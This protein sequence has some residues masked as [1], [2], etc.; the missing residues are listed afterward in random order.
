[1]NNK[2]NSNEM[3]AKLKETASL[4]PTDSGVYLMKD[5]EGKIIYIG[6]AKSIRNRLKSYFTGEK[7][8]KTSVLL[9]NLYSIETIIVK[10]EYEALLLE[11]TLIKQHSPRYNISLKDGKTY[12]LIKITNEKFPRII[13]T[14][15]IVKDDGL[16]FG[17]FPN[18]QAVNTTLALIDKIFPLRK[19][20]KMKKNGCMYYHIGRCMAPC[21]KKII[22][23]DYSSHV[24]LVQKLLEGETEAIF[25]DLTEQMHNAARELKF[26][27]AAEIRN[28][29]K[30][31]EGLSVEDSLVDDKNIE[32]RDYIAWAM[33][34]VL[35]TFTVFSMRDGK[36]TGR[37]LYRARSA[38]SE[39]ESLEVFITSYYDTGRQPPPKVYVQKI[40]SQNS[41]ENQNNLLSDWFMEKFSYIP[42]LLNPFDKHHSAILAM[43]H[44]NAQEDLQKRLKE[45]GAGFALDEL[46]QVL[47]LQ[48]KPYRIE[49][50]D[51]SH[52]DGKYPVASLVSFKN[53]IPDKKNYRHFKLRT[54]IGLIDDYAAM[55]EVIQRR[56]TRILNENKELPDFILVDGGLGQVNAAKQVLDE[57]EITCDI[58]GL[59][60]QNEEI[61]LAQA[62]EP[63]VLSKRS[64]A[65]KILQFVRDESHRFALNLNK[66]L[67][68]KDIR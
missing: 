52:L 10:N 18:G 24:R 22:A 47:G 26:E 62:K 55:R 21:I 11:N 66:K 56:Y 12:P 13:K 43:A 49:G 34:G 17:P 42:E 7:D 35:A 44:Q 31:I 23:D 38:A 14:R 9:K 29:I 64:E 46:A 51:I 32:K 65:L 50:F 45:R 37:D 30:A 19:C 59:A 40:I 1:M 41:Q 33:D 60:E 20:K 28:T 54:V 61:W 63:I 6:K 3:L 68:S 39:L 58:A 25:I 5:I 48:R 15:R 16:Y 57:L 2:V 4:A 53:G 36:M 27:K 67:R 8:P